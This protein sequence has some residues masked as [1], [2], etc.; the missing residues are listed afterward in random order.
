MF[1]LSFSET[2]LQRFFFNPN[3]KFD[4]RKKESDFAQEFQRLEH[5]LEYFVIEKNKIFVNLMLW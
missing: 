2:V 5:L 4:I 1:F 3:F